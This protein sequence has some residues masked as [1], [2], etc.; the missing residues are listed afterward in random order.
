MFQTTLHNITSTTDSV[1]LHSHTNRPMFRKI[2]RM[3]TEFDALYILLNI[4]CNWAQLLLLH[5]VFN[6]S[7][8]PVKAVSVEGSQRTFAGAS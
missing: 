6:I 2:Q 5:I 3:Q 4:L 8:T 7:I 1:K